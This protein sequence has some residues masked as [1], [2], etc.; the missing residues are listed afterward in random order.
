M[1]HQSRKIAIVGA[2][3]AG[4]SAAWLLRQ[5]HQIT[6][7]EREARI[8]GHANTVLVPMEG[9]N[10]AVDTGFI[11]YNEQNYPNLVALFDHLKVP[12]HAS[13]MSFAVSARAG[14]LEYSSDAP[15][16]LF[17]QRRNLFR[18]AFWRMLA[19]V[20][21]FYHAAPADLR[22]GRLVGLSLG[23]YLSAGKYTH[24]FIADH[25]LPMGAAIWSAGIDEMLQ[26]PAE[27]F[28]RFFESHGLLKLRD[29][30]RWRTV[31][32]GSRVYVERLTDRFTANIR[33]NADIRAIIRHAGGVDV[34]DVTGER[35]VF[36]DVVLAVHADEALALLA[37][38]NDQERATL[39]A[40][41]YTT[42]ESYLH[43]DTSLMPDRRRV[44]ASWNYLTGVGPDPGPPQVSYW[45]NRL[46]GLETPRP[47]FA[48]L[49][50]QKPPAP[51]HLIATFSYHHPLYDAG[52]L[53]AQ[54]DLWQLQ[55]QRKTWFCGSYF[56]F[57]FHEDALQ[58][59]LDVAEALGGVRRPWCV[60]N[61]SDRLYL[62]DPRVHGVPSNRLQEAA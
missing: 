53:A 32:G 20:R 30:P 43:C 4:L 17:G 5:R 62:P 3:I 24:H 55:G 54:R 16:G 49:N 47:L 51:E 59:G 50:P 28:V 57:G 60:A 22:A 25:L 46:Q 21:R 14:Q 11:V 15:A 35:Q 39:G 13:D 10:H 52:A 42:N 26:Y 7:F 29:R 1:T 23:E 18:P 61:Q 34:V 45:L 6:V 48:T 2:G 36:D 27:S 40:I 37:D 56:G 9:L 38:A 8:G 58:S 12:T 31:T 33:R 41:R 44:W 19:D